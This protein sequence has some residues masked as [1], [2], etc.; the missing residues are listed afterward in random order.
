LSGLTGWLVLAALAISAASTFGGGAYLH[1]FVTNALMLVALLVPLM[2]LLPMSGEFSTRT[3][4]VTFSL[5]PVRGRVVAAK[6]VAAI[7]VAVALTV[8]SAL[9]AVAAAGA[10]CP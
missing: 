1:T 9:L 8:V 4:L 5:V 6:S 2:G 7:L 10:R 3:L